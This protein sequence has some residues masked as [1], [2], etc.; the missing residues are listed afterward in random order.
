LGTDEYGAID[1]SLVDSFAEKMTQGSGEPPAGAATVSTPEVSLSRGSWTATQ[2]RRNIIFSYG[3][4]LA[5]FLGVLVL[6]PLYTRFLG[7]QLY[8]EWIVITTIATYLAL[9]NMGI[10]QAL[11]NRIAEA[12]VKGR[13]AEVRTL[14]S[15][16][17]FAYT[18]IAALM[19]GLFAIISPLLTRVLMGGADGTA[20]MTLFVVASLYALALPWNA[21]LAALRGFERVDQEQVISACAY[22]GRN[23]GLAV[24]VL[25][26][27]GF[28]SMA[29][30]QGGAI[31]ARGL[32]A[33]LRALRL[34]KDPGPRPSEFSFATLRSLLQPGL[35]FF[36]LQIAGVVGFGIDN[37]VIAY[38]LGPK[39]VTRYAVPYSLVMLGAG[40]FGTAMTAALPSITLSLARPRPEVQAGTFVFTMRVAMMYGGICVLALSTAGPWILQLWA[41][42]GVFPGNAT[43]RWQLS[44]LLVQVFIA[45]AYAILVA[46]TRHYGAAALHVIESAL[47]LVLSVW[48]VYRWGLSGVIA[49]TVAA[50]LLTS[51][52][53]IPR[54]ALGALEIPPQNAIKQLWPTITLAFGASAGAILWGLS[55]GNRLRL[56]SPAVTAIVVPVFVLLYIAIALTRDDRRRLFGWISGAGFRTESA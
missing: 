22:L 42:H 44:L 21:Y 30:V 20:S 40:F 56:K 6:V 48:W 17:F 13:I 35:G 41:G 55:A 8:G 28:V 31:V 52:W 36:V 15:T 2:I 10:D 26:R 54:A 45:P 25:T 16:S 38:A 11:T 39:A 19:I 27:L 49:G 4:Q 32:M 5:G 50:R 14:I 43:F 51:A 3:N 7:P 9:A 47:N 46:S 24:T 29:I 53:Y 33:Y 18:A 12:V 23:A 34:V 37:I 1:C